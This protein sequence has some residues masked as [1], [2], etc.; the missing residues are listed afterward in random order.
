VGVP[1]PPD[2]RQIEILRTSTAPGVSR[3][4]LGSDADFFNTT[5]QDWTDNGPEAAHY[6]WLRAN[7]ARYG[8]LQTYT[9]ESPKNEPAIS[10]ERW[11]SMRTGAST[12]ST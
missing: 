1:A 2:D 5:P 6:Q 8:F 9:A 4:H 12:C 3:H 10:E 11:H 7:A